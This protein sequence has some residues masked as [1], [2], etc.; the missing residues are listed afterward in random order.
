MDVKLNIVLH[1]NQKILH[2]STAKRKVVKAGKR[3]GKTKWALFEL[4][5]RAGQPN[6]VLWYVAPTYKQ[7]KSIAWWEL[8][9]ILPPAI[10]R[11]SIE[12]ELLK[13][14]INGT[15]I[16]LIGAD[17]EDSLRGPKLNAV[18]FDEAA[19]TNKYAW[20]G[21]IQGQLSPEGFAY[22]ISS[23]NK[24]GNNWFTEF[25]AEAAR[26]Q[27]NGDSN[28]AA[29]YY[30][31]YDNPYHTREW[32]E[33]LKNNTP[34]DVWKLEYMAVES[35]FAG[36]LYSEFE[37]SEHIGFYD[38][39][40][41]LPYFR[42]IDWG[43]SHPTVCLWAQIDLETKILYITDEYVKSGLVIADYAND[44]KGRTG[45]KKIEWTVIDPSTA[46]R[47]SQTGR[48]DA[49]E[50]AR[51]GITCIMADNKD[52]G[53][54]ITKMFLKKGMLKIH[55]RCKNLIYGLKNV[56]RGFEGR[57]IGDASGDD[58]TD[59][60]RYITLRVHDS[61]HGMNVYENSPIFKAGENIRE[62]NF[63]DPN[64]LGANKN[65]SMNWL[66]EEVA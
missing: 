56:Q 7:A 17:N 49:I 14:L 43:I 1:E 23:P 40:K 8:N 39:S 29:F 10:V 20:E 60:L 51:H 18:V 11:R 16:Q 55:P 24:Y 45:D 42:G 53:Y 62:I 47:N 3:F 41:S 6:G 15:R 59:V 57:P 38:G 46:K 37:P 13:E 50:F 12:N 48:S 26:K 54:D 30:T 9:T 32:I 33:D 27:A 4:C 66:L 2:A 63:N 34:D 52:R 22:F 64:F 31:I 58:A 65:Q 61:I 5:K 35:D 25:H 36:Q 28:W 44:I 19:Y 21:I